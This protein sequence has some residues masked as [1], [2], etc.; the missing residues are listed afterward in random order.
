[1]S[2]PPHTELN[3]SDPGAAQFLQ[4]LSDQQL[5]H[6]AFAVPSKNEP[7]RFSQ[8]LETPRRTPVPK[9]FTF[10]ALNSDSR[11]AKKQI[12]KEEETKDVGRS[13][14]DSA[15]STSSIDLMKEVEKVKIVA[16]VVGDVDWRFYA[17]GGSLCLLN[18]VAAWDATSLAVVLPVFSISSHDAS[19]YIY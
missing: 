19:D 3:S 8:F 13:R 17:T 9:R 2:A 6:L 10:D 12:E 16:E 5:R 18:L 11:K 4:N 7:E 14:S 1:M 15:N